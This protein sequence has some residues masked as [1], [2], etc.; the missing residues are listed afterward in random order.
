MSHKNT[1]KWKKQRGIFKNYARWY[2][3]C[4]VNEKS[5]KFFIAAN[6]NPICRAGLI[7]LYNLE[8][9]ILKNRYKRDKKTT[10]KYFPE[11][12][13]IFCLM[14]LNQIHFTAWC[15][16][17]TSVEVVEQSEIPQ[18]HLQMLTFLYLKKP[19]LKKRWLFITDSIN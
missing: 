6:K 9:V 18:S 15:L 13:K 19:N 4:L 3:F 17:G 7:N 2:Q 11:I 1:S 10:L 5:F 14:C 8:S 16:K 12:E